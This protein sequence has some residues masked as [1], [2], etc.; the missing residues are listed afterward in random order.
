[1]WVLIWLLL[2][3]LLGAIVNKAMDVGLPVAGAALTGAA[4][5]FLG[6]A[7]IRAMGWWRR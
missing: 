7:V 4:A 5:A 1:M 2:G 6:L 3:A